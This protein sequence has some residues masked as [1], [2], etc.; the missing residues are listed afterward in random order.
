MTPNMERPLSSIIE[1]FERTAGITE[2]DF[3][4]SGAAALTLA[5]RSPS[6]AVVGG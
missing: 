3:E 4:W 6:T 1:Y 2:T 5:A